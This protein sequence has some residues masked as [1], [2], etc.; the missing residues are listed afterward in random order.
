[1]NLRL[2]RTFA[3]LSG[4]AAAVTFSPGVRAA[5]PIQLVL[6]QMTDSGPACTGGGSYYPSV[7]AQAELVA[8]TS[9]CDLARGQNTDGNSE[10]FIKNVGGG[11]LKQLT[12]TTGDVGV[13]EPSLSPGGGLVAFASALDLVPGQNTDGNNEIFVIHA[14]GTG[15]AQLTHTTGGRTQYGFAGNTHPVFD[16]LGQHIVFSSDRDLVAGGNTDGNNDLFMMNVDGSGVSQLT[17]TIGGWG[18]DMG[19]LDQAD[20]RVVFDSDRDLVGQNPDLGYEIFAMNVN[21]SGLVQ[22]TNSDSSGGQSGNTFPR[23]TPDGQS[24]FF[25][26]DQ[27][28]VGSN[29]GMINQAYHMNG[30]GSAIVQVTSC[31]GLFGAVPWSVAQKGRSVALESDCDLVP[32]ANLD[33]NGELFLETWKPA[34]FPPS[35]PG[36]R[37]QPAGAAALSHGPRA[38]RPPKV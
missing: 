14:D 20:Q 8:F 23:W 15:L 13:Y 24:I 18:V 4:L 16:P 12:H 32:G 27:E 29:P 35:Q 22:L 25:A 19:G 38:L 26:S 11:G 10:L 9:F 37:Q 31:M 28:L 34:Q 2:N 6:R 3:L 21:G 33:R 5:A 36:A 1:M 17:F 30:D 7:D